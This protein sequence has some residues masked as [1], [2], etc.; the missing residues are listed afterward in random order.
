M[1]DALRDLGHSDQGPGDLVSVVVP[2]R[3][4]AIHLESCLRSLREQTYDRLEIIV[5]D[6]FSND[7]TLAI[8]RQWADVIETAGDE[9]AAQTNRG[10]TV[11]SGLYVFRVDSDFV[12]EPS[13]VRECLEKI[14]HGAEAVVVHNTPD[15]SVGRLARIRKFEIDMYKYDLKH[16]AARFLSRALFL[17]IGGY[18]QDLIAGEDYDF[19]NRLNRRG[20][21]TEF[22]EAEAVHL[23][24]PRNLREAVAKFYLYGGQLV[25]FRMLNV[26]EAPAQLG[27]FRVAYLR[28]WASFLRHPL[29]A[30]GFVGYHAIKFAAGAAGYAVERAQMNR[31]T[32]PVG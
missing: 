27:F 3:N 13:V 18:N 22:V 4:S 25:R 20:V 28:H 19:Q 5:V 15:A 16:S 32:Q 31:T 14:R 2:T 11:A 30:L 21:R 7:E 23:G 1:N 24:E 12:L 29:L 26:T 9:R 17:S 8:A 10:V 6:N